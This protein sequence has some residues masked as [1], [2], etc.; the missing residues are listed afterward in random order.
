M[1][2]FR[3]ISKKALIAILVL[4]IIIMGIIS[5]AD[6]SHKKDKRTAPLREEE[7]PINLYKK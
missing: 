1:K 5:Y 6:S 2:K 7:M 4:I 3:K